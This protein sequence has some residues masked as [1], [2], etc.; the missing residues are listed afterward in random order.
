MVHALGTT[1][2]LD[3]H[4]QALSEAGRQDIVFDAAGK[5]SR[6]ACAPILEKGGAFVSVRSP[7][8][9]KADELRYLVGLAAEGRI[10]PFIDRRIRLEDVP[11]AH[12]LVDSGRKRGNIVVL[13]DQAETGT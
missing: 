12:R 4:S 10:K 7:T 11:E 2:V 5:L 9:E 3:Y 13:V 6:R 1:K 8:S